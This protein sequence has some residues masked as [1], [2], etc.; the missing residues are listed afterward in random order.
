MKITKQQLK[1]IVKECLVEI[2]S[3]GIGGLSVG[4]NPSSKDE[5]IIRKPIRK[6]E[7]SRPII[8]PALRE[9]INREAGG[10]KMMESIFADTALNSLPQMMSNHS[11]SDPSAAGQIAAKHTPEE[12]FGEDI[13][14][15]WASLAFDQS[16]NKKL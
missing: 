6:S 16:T 10:N 1:I 12:I 15:K 8:T 7:P 14:S 13:A 5:S 3:E 4:A 2:L 11:P 9:S